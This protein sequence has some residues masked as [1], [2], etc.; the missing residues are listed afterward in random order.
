M[1][2]RYTTTDAGRPAA[3]FAERLDCTVR[4][5]ALG[6]G[7]SYAVAHKTCRDAGR[8]F[9]RNMHPDSVCVA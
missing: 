1:K 6:T 9:G 8:R 5:L 4:S 3:G 2:L 7:M